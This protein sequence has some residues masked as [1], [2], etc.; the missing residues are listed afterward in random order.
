MPVTERADVSSQKLDFNL[1]SGAPLMDCSY[2]RFISGGVRPLSAWGKHLRQARKRERGRGRWWSWP[3]CS[4]SDSYQRGW[5]VSSMICTCKWTLWTVAFWVLT[6]SGLVIENVTSLKNHRK[7]QNSIIKSPLSFRLHEADDIWSSSLF[8]SC[9]VL[10]AGEGSLW[11]M[12]DDHWGWSPGN[13]GLRATGP[14][15]V[16]VVGGQG[17]L[18]NDP[19]EVAWIEVV[20]PKPFPSVVTKPLGT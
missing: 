17:H 11:L 16:C 10:P 9:T 6:V 5:S 20:V 7:I 2:E 19:Q 14:L 12:G 4:V 18:T 1:G 13:V 15:S 3:L 8:R